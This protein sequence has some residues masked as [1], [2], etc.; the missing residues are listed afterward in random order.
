M[1]KNIIIFSDGACLGN[2]GPG[3]YGTIVAFEEQVIELGG[4]EKHTTN[5]RMEITGALEG[6]K[7]LQTGSLVDLYT[8][9]QYL[10]NGITKWIHGWIKKNW[11]T[12]D[13][14][15]VSNEDLWQDL[16]KTIQQKRL[17]INWHYVR[18]H[19]GTPANE[20]VDEIATTFA[21]KK[22]IELYDGSRADYPTPLTATTEPLKTFD[23]SNK[24]PSKALGYLSL[25]NGTLQKH[26]TWPDCEARVKGASGAK[27]KKFTST[28]EEHKI[29]ESWGVK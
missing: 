7:S 12:A 20:R 1:N 11:Q 17:T 25:V 5:N 28:E 27:F 2:P 13:G 10:I 14:S 8:D 19:A 9:S 3:G 22:S 26:T 29:L 18:G 6:L 4:S 21:A 15:A 24:K 23:P 16:Y